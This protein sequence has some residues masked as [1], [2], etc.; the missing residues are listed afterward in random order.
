MKKT[1]A[2]GMGRL[3]EHIDTLTRG[4]LSRSA[5]RTQVAAALGIS[6]QAVAALETGGGPRASLVAPLA[7]ILGVDVGLFAREL[8]DGR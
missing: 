4:G 1:V 3:R 8:A 5:A 6:S 2:H 7:D